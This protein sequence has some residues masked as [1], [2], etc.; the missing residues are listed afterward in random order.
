MHSMP[1]NPNDRYIVT[2]FFNFGEPGMFKGVGFEGSGKIVEVGPDLDA[3]LV[4]K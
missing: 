1:I 3:D 4:G 2:G